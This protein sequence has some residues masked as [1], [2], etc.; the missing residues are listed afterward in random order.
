VA[1]VNP[2]VQDK[3]ASALGIMPAIDTSG[4]ELAGII[5]KDADTL[6]GGAFNLAAK[7]AADVK[8]S[9][10]KIQDINDTLTAYQKTMDIET[11]T[12]DMITKNKQQYVNDPKS[13]RDVI[14]GECQGFLNQVKDDTS[15][16]EN[17]K[18]KMVGILT[19][20][21]RGKMSEVDSWYLAQDTA[22]SK[23]KIQNIFGQLYNI[24]A[25]ATDISGI[26]QALGFADT[27]DDNTGMNFGDLINFT[28]GAKGPEEIEKAKSGIAEAYLLG[29]LDR[30]EHGKCIATLDSGALDS[31]LSPEVKHK[32]RNM[33]LTVQ[34]AEEK[35]ERMDNMMSIFDVKTNAIIKSANG[36]YTISDAVAD[37]NKIM[38]MGGKPLTSLVNQAVSSEKRKEKKDYQAG[39]NTA[40]SNITNELGQITKKGKIDPEAELK[41]I[42]S[43]QNTVEANKQYLT[44]KEY[45]SYMSKINEPKVKRI[46]KMGKNFLGMPQ[47]EMSGKDNY[48]KSY[49]AIYNF[50]EKA[51]A[52]K[53]N[54]T[55]AINNMIV[56]FVKYSEQLE[57]KQGKEMTAQQA[58]NLCNKVISDQRRRTNPQLNNIPASGRVMKDKNGRV[59]KVYPGGRY[60]IIK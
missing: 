52:G 8:A 23:V 33:A 41:D 40:L 3:L 17:V 48:S 18:S 46:R 25:G 54:R 27:Q 42:I 6:A 58:Q 44:A 37:N 19:N 20:S 29:M 30:S 39:R 45:S 31:Y 60:E 32:Y 28:Y 9:R 12:R 15:I 47:G 34:R 16:S 43:F 55:N 5:K 7:K 13:G 51:Y 2:Y 10:D 36:E 50:A 53:E 21:M 11:Q 22:N 56:D 1:K 24:A 4:A 35:Q 49:L 38:A 26:S 57:N 59:V 14:Q